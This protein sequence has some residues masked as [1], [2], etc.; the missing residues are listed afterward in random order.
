[1]ARTL[2]GKQP[3]TVTAS[4]ISFT[5]LPSAGSMPALKSYSYRVQF[6]NILPHMI[7]LYLFPGICIISACGANYYLDKLLRKESSDDI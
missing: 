6:S 2:L 5:A 7:A 1:M 3:E 4:A